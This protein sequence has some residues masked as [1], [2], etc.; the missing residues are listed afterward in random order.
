M[1]VLALDYGAARTGVAVSDA[2]GTLAR[3]VGVVERAATDP[4][5]DRLA[6]LV[7]EHEAERV[8]VGLPLTLRGEHG[9]QAQET[10]AFVAQLEARLTI[11]VET[12]DER[13]TTTLAQRE[14][15]DRARGRACRSASPPGLAR[16]AGEDRM[17]AILVLA[18]AAAAFAAGLRQRC[19]GD[20]AADG[21]RSRL[22]SGCASSSR[23]GSRWRRWATRVEAVRAIAREKRGVTPRLTGKAYLAAA[24]ERPTAEAV[25]QR[26]EAGVDRGLPLPGA[27]RV[28]AVH[29]GQGARRRP[30]DG[31]PAPLRLARPALREVEEP[32][33]VRRA[34][35]RV[36]DREGDRRSPRAPARRGRDLQPA[37]QPD[38]A[39][40]RCDHPLRPRTSRAPSR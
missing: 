8:V 18:A 19:G 25:P 17:R 24:G 1:R 2:T 40:D 3:P 37:S 13:F 9:A 21:D 16:S 14:R 36:D 38:A 23:R 5:L 28:L 30:A 22:S 29:D 15:V 4:G 11:P 35:D 39:R 6:A 32:D 10:E 12:Y 7:D 26:L 34:Q 27:V 31:V 33:A 20:T